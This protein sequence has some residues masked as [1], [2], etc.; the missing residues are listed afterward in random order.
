MQAVPVP[1]L[2][3]INGSFSILYISFVPYPIASVSLIFVKLT[4]LNDSFNSFDLPPVTT[5]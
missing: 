5:I 1:Q 2:K 3:V 4:P